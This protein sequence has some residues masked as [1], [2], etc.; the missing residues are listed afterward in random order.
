M[1]RSAKY[2]TFKG[3]SLVNEA[4]ESRVRFLYRSIPW[5]TLILVWISTQIQLFTELFFLISLFLPVEGT[6]MKTFQN[7]C[8][9]GGKSTS[10]VI[11]AFLAPYFSRSMEAV[12]S[13]L[14]PI[15][16][17]LYTLFIPFSCCY[18][19]PPDPRSFTPR[20]PPF[21]LPGKVRGL[22]HKG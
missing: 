2:P 1:G 8:F 18:I 7:Y 12:S 19:P 9:A 10:N 5:S 3:G 11:E 21:L 16:L 4:W 6:Q 22:V 15:R 17:Y 13:R 14:S 20:P